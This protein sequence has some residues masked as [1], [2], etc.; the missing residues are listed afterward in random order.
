M[1]NIAYITLLSIF[2]IGCANEN[3][4]G[5]IAEAEDKIIP[6]AESDKQL[7]ITILLD[8]SDRIEPSK[9]PTKPEH[10]ERDIEVVNFL[11]D[12]FKSEMKNKGAFNAKGKMKVIF[13]PRPKDDEINKIASELSVDLSTKIS[14]EKKAI[15][16]N[17]KSKFTDNLERIYSKTIKTKSYPG[18]DIWRFFKNDVVDFAITDDANYRNILVVLTDGYLYHQDSQDNIDNRSAYLLPQN[19]KSNGF[20]NN[21][22]KEKFEKGDFGYISTRQDLNNLEIL[23]LEI[24]P[25]PSAKDDEDVI[26]A[27]LNK[28]FK[29]MNVS[30]FELYNS[31]LPEYTKTRIEK[32]INNG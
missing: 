27:Y 26:K 16:D 25:E 2:I 30:K 12:L 13:N 32:F 24:S 7:N 11:T 23:V 15:F 28:W 17:L 9:Y 20:R 18:S 19:V 4:K 10:F 3:K 6:I 1:K 29:E 31:D 5:T 8:L 22:W 21:N 14:K